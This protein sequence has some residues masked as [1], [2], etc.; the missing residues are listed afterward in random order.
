MSPSPVTR[1][2]E[3]RM[4]DLL[5]HNHGFSEPEKWV[6]YGL[7]HDF[8]P[9]RASKLDGCPDCGG[10][11]HRLMGQYVYYSTLA[12]LNEC[13]TCGLVYSDA[14]IDPDVIRHHFELVY[15]DEEYFRLGK[16]RVFAQLARLT[17]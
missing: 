3:S 14:R 16:R 11:D 9:I 5:R 13:A 2:A 7:A 12:R 15:K 10:T 17:D 4:L 8:E 1:E 6:G